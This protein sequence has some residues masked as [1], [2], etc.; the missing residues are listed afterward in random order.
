LLNKSDFVG[1]YWTSSEL[2]AFQYVFIQNIKI[3]MDSYFNV[4]ISPVACMSYISHLLFSYDV[5]F[6]V[7]LWCFV[8]V[9]N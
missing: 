8:I 2:L 4:F 9:V 1:L 7:F 5:L 3:S 6:L